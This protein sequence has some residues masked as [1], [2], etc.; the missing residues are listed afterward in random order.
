MKSTGGPITSNGIHPC[1]HAVHKK[2]GT[3]SK[4]ALAPAQGAETKTTGTTAEE[5]KKTKGNLL[6][7]HKLGLRGAMTTT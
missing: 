2:V 5:Q 6:Y 4:P 1:T 3:P 7:P